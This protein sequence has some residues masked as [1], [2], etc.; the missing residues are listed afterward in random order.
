MTDKSVG[1]VYSWILHVRDV[2]LWDEFS[3]LAA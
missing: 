2:D 1:P 3:G